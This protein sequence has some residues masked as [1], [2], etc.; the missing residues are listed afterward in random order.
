MLVCQY[1]ILCEILGA[2]RAGAPQAKDPPQPRA[3]GPLRRRLGHA[4]RQ[5]LV[6]VPHHPRLR[7]PAPA[8]R[9]ADDPLA[10]GALRWIRGHG[11]VVPIPTWGRVWL[12]MLG[13]YPWQGVQPI[14]PEMWLL[15]DATPGPPAPALQ[16]H[17]PDLPRA[18]VRLRR[19]PAGPP[20]AAPAAD[21][22]RAL[23]RGLRPRPV[24]RAPRRDRRH[25]PPRG[26]RRR[27]ARRLRRHA[28]AREV[29]PR[30]AAPPR[31]RPRR[32]HILLRVRTAPT[33]CA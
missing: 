20:V 18:L 12:A 26:P 19:A 3:A 6:A 4:P 14:L 27:P 17:A 15:P 2:D 30:P 33:T 10:A 28:R 29:H 32:E 21:P 23:P 22:R 9:P 24:R 16:P 5:R 11:G 1:V 8:R 7:R 13:M 25:R 31:P